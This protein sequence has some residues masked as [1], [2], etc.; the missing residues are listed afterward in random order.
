MSKAGE[1]GNC[2]QDTYYQSFY[3]YRCNQQLYSLHTDISLQTSGKNHFAAPA[4]LNIR[5]LPV[6]EAKLQAM[7]V[8]GL[9]PLRFVLRQPAHSSQSICAIQCRAGVYVQTPMGPLLRAQMSGLSR[10]APSTLTSSMF[11]FGPST[12]YA[13]T[14]STSVRLKYVRF[15]PLHNS[16]APPAIADTICKRLPIQHYIQT[17]PYC[18]CVCAPL[19]SWVKYELWPIHTHSSFSHC[20]A[21]NVDLFHLL[22][23][24]LLQQLL[25]L[26]L[27][28][29]ERKHCSSC[30]QH[31]RNE[32]SDCES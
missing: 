1:V 28:A 27:I 23:L 22:L 5:S 30:T 14:I 10:M 20:K 15:C 3:R 16:L 26:A 8:P 29:G 2:N 9:K 4:F 21:Y 18:R 32:F 6:A 7:L 31:Q 11:F 24:L 25:L 17:W 13:N 12:S 19:L